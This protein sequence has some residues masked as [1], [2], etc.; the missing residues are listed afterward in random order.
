MHRNDS[1]PRHRD[2]PGFSTVEMMIVIAIIAVL[3]AFTLPSFIEYYPEWRL[4][5]A[6]GDL[7]SNMQFAKV[8]AVKSNSP[9]AV[10]FDPANNRYRVMTDALMYLSAGTMGRALWCRLARRRTAKSS[11]VDTA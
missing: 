8:N 4:R 1:C 9:W 7:F 11:I 5:R 6:A 10:V 3:A 2:A